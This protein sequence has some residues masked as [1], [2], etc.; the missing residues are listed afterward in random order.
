LTVLAAALG[1]ALI[2]S[3]AAGAVTLRS[4]LWV[5]RFDGAAH[6]SDAACCVE[7][8]P[9]SSMVFVTGWSNGANSTTAFVTEALSAATGTRLWVSRYDGPVAGYNSPT[10]LAVSP[11][12]SKVFVTGASSG[13]IPTDDP[14]EVVDYAT[15]A[16][17]TRNGAQL[18]VRRYN[19]PG[20]SNDYPFAIAANTST[21][22]V[23][24]QSWGETTQF[25]ETTV[26]YDASTGTTR[27]VD[28]YNGPGFQTIND[29]VGTAVEVA[30]DGSAVFVTGESDGT[31]G[32]DL[33]TI[34]YDPVT[35]ARL[36]LRRFVDAAG[37]PK[38][39]VG[40]VPARIFITAERW[41]D[42]GSVTLAYN[43]SGSLLWSKPARATTSSV[44]AS[45]DGSRAFVT[46]SNSGHGTGLD[47]VTRAYTSTG[48]QIW[49]ARYTGPGVAPDAATAITVSANGARVFVT[50]SIS[51]AVS[52]DYAT[53]KYGAAFGSMIWVGRYDGPA[54]KGD[55]A[56][57]IAFSRIG[58]PRVFVTGWSN[59]S[60][61]FDYL[62]VAYSA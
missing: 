16:F 8:S 23:T 53:I 55:S 15:V 22:F 7:P 14:A 3:S 20:D 35:G 41:S 45:P 37:F 25:D 44:A 32:F 40:G 18:W 29:D 46:G 34:A 38:M 31:L 10:G 56:Q 4:P 51:G 17:D 5:S 43:A 57:A 30:A 36:W 49:K 48:T 9:D 26:A 60:T 12:G 54:H 33:A 11:D 19:G 42:S 47:Y 28:R 52:G 58:G 24:G 27:W 61:D 39:A 62:T 13:A 50:G 2:G 6:I 1:L 21:V 59:D